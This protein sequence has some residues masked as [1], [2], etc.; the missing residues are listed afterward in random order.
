VPSRESLQLV[1]YAAIAA[2]VAIAI[3]KF[4]A[5]GW[6]G[7]SAMLS[8]AIHSSVDTVDGLL[9]L[10]GA[11]LSQKPADES[12]PFGYGKDLYFWTLIVGILVFAVG[13]GMSAFEGIQHL[14][15][16]HEAV[17]WRLNLLVIGVSV[18]FEGGSFL[19]ARQRFSDYRRANFAN[20]GLFRSIRASKDPTAFAVFLEDGAALVGLLLAATGVLLSHLLG[21]PVYDGVA[22]IAIGVLLAGVAVLL[23]YESRDLLIGESAM[24][25]VVRSIRARASQARG[26]ARVHRVLT[27]QLGPDNVLVAL[28]A[29]F[30]PGLTGEELGNVTRDLEDAILREHPSIKHVY[31]DA[32]GLH[33]ST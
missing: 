33:G 11:R 29:T 22:S 12:H 17:G 10:V 6:S 4:I 2:N 3:T 27:M 26:V 15:S 19:F 23:T 16:P 25:G 20:A 8:E 5:S 21:T 14:R 31:V 13:G 28:E 7:S 32:H 30:E 18:L 24:R 1:T 9:L